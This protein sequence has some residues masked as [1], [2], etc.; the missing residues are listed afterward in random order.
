MRIQSLLRSP[1]RLLAL[2][3]IALAAATTACGPIQSHA[4]IGNSADYSTNV[5][6]G[7]VQRWNPCSPIHYMVNTDSAPGELSRVFSAVS[8]ISQATGLRFVYDGATSF[9]PESGNWNQ[10]SD[11]VISF[12]NHDGMA[13]GSSYLAG[14]NQLGEGGF[15]STYVTSNDR[16]TNYKITKGYAVI[17]AVGYGYSSAKVRNDTLLHELGHAVGLNH[18][19]YSSEIMYPVI[20]DYSPSGYTAGDLSGLAQVGSGLG[21]L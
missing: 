10:P 19:R 17:D 7:W 5:Y 18:A 12:A 3:G 13:G 8:S 16:I 21:C 6:S 14:A 15:Q 20:T 1:R 2:G 4:T 11:L 9:V